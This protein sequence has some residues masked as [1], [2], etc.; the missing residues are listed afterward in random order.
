MVFGICGGFVLF[1]VV[2]VHVFTPPD[3]FPPK[4]TKNTLFVA[5][6]F[7][8]VLSLSLS[9]SFLGFVIVVV[10]FGLFVF[11]YLL[12]L[13]VLVKREC[14]FRLFVFVICF[15]FVTLAPVVFLVVC[16]PV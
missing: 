8:V 12:L 5:S 11:L 2:F 10:R 6:V 7:L 4:I 16:L 9:L 15:C 14:T 3:R 13:L 1:G